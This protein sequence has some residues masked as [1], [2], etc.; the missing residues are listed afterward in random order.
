[1]G[2]LADRDLQEET[3]GRR[4]FRLRASSFNLPRGKFV[5]CC[6]D[7]FRKLTS[8]LPRGKLRKPGVRDRMGPHQGRHFRR[9]E[10]VGKEPLDLR[11]ASVGCHLDQLAGVFRREM[12]CQ[13]AHRG[14]MQPAIGQGGE[15]LG[16][17]CSLSNGYCYPIRGNC[18][19]YMKPNL[20]GLNP[21]WGI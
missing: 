8:N 17:L 13:Q 10:A 3:L 4:E 16:D 14:E 9:R 21:I 7:P 2:A 19:A 18:V 1:M 6:T 5:V 20:P 15:D 12:G 11:L